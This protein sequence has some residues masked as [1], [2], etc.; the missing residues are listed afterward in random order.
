LQNVQE[1]ASRFFNGI[2][3]T[4][5]SRRTL[6]KTKVCRLSD[7]FTAIEVIFVW[8]RQRHLIITIQGMQDHILLPRLL[9]KVSE[10]PRQFQ[11]KHTNQ[12][13]IG[14]SRINHW[15]Q[16]IEEGLYAKFTTNRSDILHC[17]V[18]QRRMHKTD[19]G[20]V[21]TALQG[22]SIVGKLIT[23]V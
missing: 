12:L 9:I 2:T 6:R 7:L 21:Q 23:K 16:H 4:Q 5:I 15:T 11:I 8:P 22:I 17:R 13:T 1:N 19:I 18:K 20:A 3:T 10:F 14:K